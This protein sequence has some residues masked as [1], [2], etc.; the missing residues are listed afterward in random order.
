MD[1]QKTFIRFLHFSRV[2]TKLRQKLTFVGFHKKTGSL[3]NPCSPLRI[4]VAIKSGEE[5]EQKMVKEGSFA[6][7]PPRL[8]LSLLSWLYIQRKKAKMGPEGIPPPL[9]LFPG[10]HLPSSLLG[11]F[12]HFPSFSTSFSFCFISLRRKRGGNGG[13]KRRGEGRATD[14]YLA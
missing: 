3:A 4:F 6:P 1:L 5:R 13:R 8:L 2:F 10:G 11:F 14:E 9:S 7:L 12:S